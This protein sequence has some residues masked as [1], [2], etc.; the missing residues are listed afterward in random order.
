MSSNSV[1][2]KIRAATVGSK[3]Q[4]RKELV[5]LEGAQVEVRQLSL[6]ERRDYMSASLDKESNSVD[7]LKL[8]V[9]A[10]I[11]SCYVPGTDEKVFEDTDEKAIGNSITGG[12]AD[13]LWEAI[14]RLSNFSV[15]DA[16][17]N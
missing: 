6:L 9:N 1:R 7:L 11:S 15:D 8:Q 14:Q 5:E 4:Y 17:K 2:D 12:Y 16:K 3:K 10:I 13:T